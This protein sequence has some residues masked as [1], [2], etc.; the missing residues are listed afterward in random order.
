MCKSCF[1]SVIERIGRRNINTAVSS[2][3]S[4]ALVAV[5]QLLVCAIEISDRLALD[6]HKA[7]TC[8]FVFISAYLIRIRL[9]FP[10]YSILIQFLY[11]TIA[12]L[13]ILLLLLF[14]TWYQRRKKKNLYST[15]DALLQ[16]NK[17]QS[18]RMRKSK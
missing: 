3:P 8:P 17:T 10:Y 7:N 5:R 1:Q 15:R 13:P 14:V 12:P 2:S 9:P 16:Q 4:R 6:K 11:S 18:A